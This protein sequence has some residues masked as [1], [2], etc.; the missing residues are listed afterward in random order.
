M[1]KR[2]DGLVEIMTSVLA[3]QKSGAYAVDNLTHALGAVANTT[4]GISTS[5][6][7]ELT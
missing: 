1:S 2:T 6:V 5:E 7:N 4:A 3:L